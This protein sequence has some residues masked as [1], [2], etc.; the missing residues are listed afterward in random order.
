[1]SLGERGDGLISG[2]ILSVERDSALLIHS[3]KKRVFAP[4]ISGNPW[5]EREN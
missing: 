3:Q 5:N 1:M 2:T 4:L